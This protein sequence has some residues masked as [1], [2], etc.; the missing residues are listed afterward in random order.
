MTEV[1]VDGRNVSN[2]VLTL[3]PG[4]TVTGRVVFEGTSTV[5]ADLTRLRVTAS[6]ADL[7]GPLREIGSSVN[8]R[9]D[10][11][12]RFTINGVVPGRYRITAG[13]AAQGW[14]LASSL[15][16]GQDTLDFPVEIKPT[17]GISG[18]VLTFTD[19][20]TEI[21]GTIVNEQGQPAPD[22]TIIVYPAEREFWTPMSRR[23][24]TQR[25][26]TDGR[27]TFRSL[28]PGEYRIAPVLDPEPGTWYDPAFLQQLDAS[29]L[30]VPLG[31]GEKKVQNLR[32]QG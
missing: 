28:P 27:F 26:G 7:P 9:V 6:P 29:A 3:Q 31:E 4:L 2:I 18:A 1:S 32:T 23:I 22:Y 24:L 5:P 16:S 25:P 19:R 17:Q 8:G 15:V 12:G 10:G 21:A 30:R 11:S 14:T 20:L 13:G